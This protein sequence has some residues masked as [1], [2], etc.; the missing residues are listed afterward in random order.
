[1]ADQAAR[2]RALFQFINGFCNPCADVIQ[3]SVEKSPLAFER[4]AA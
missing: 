2:R 3:L 1:M 4:Q